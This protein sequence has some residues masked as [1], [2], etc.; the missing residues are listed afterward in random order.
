M[1]FSLKKFSIILLILIWY[2]FPKISWARVTPADIINDQKASFQARKNSY[3]SQN[4]AK[5]DFFNQAIADLNTK[6]TSEL[7]QNLI[8]QGQIL[9][10]YVRRTGYQEDG[11]RDG[12]HR[13]TDKPV[14]NAR[15]WVTYAH[16]AAAYQAGRVYIINLSSQANINNDIV[17]S[18]NALQSDISVLKSKVTKSQD[19]VEGILNHDKQ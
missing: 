16:E 13:N 5:L 19:L 1:F 6:I 15:Y 7:E 18:I 12:I 9:D 11:G 3:S 14:E 17:N 2:I 4:Q 8:R 10:E